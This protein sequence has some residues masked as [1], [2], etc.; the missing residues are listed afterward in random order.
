MSDLKV[1]RRSSRVND[2]TPTINIINKSAQLRHDDFLT[3]VEACELQ[4]AKHVIP[5][6]RR[7]NLNI[8]K[9]QPED[10]GYPLIIKDS[11]DRARS[12]GYHTASKDGVA[13]GRVFVSAIFKYQGTIM[14]GPK[15]V[16][17]V[18]THEVIE[19][20]CNPYSNLWADTGR[21]K[22]VCYEAC[23]PVEASCYDIETSGG[24][25]VS[26][27]NFVLPAWFDAQAHAD[28]K[29]DWLDMLNSPFEMLDGSY[30]SYLDTKTGRIVKDFDGKLED[31]S[32]S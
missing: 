2:V 27:T 14:N 11:A 15:S 3:I 24:V 30:M 12:L 32:E 5:M 4:L 8:V 23:D 20:Y 26:V 6:W 16:S 13:W 9:N 21:G 7:G 1:V 19:M 31:A 17:S 25:K 18:L 28:S 10:V 29:F 22:L